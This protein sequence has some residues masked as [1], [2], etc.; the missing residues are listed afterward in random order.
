MTTEATTTITVRV[1]EGLR[2]EIDEL[3]AAMGRNRQYVAAEALRRYVALESW[4][5]A[6][7]S[8]GIRAADAGEFA[9]DEEVEAIFTKYDSRA[10]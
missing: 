6:R 3:A 2:D 10:S 1:P 9:S 8:E 4:Q 7:I 5:V